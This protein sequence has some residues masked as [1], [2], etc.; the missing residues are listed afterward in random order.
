MVGLAHPW[1]PASTRPKTMADTP[2]VEVSAPA[3]SKRPRWRSVSTMTSRPSSQTTTPMGTFT[4]ITHRQETSWVSSPPATSPV[5]PPA[6]DT[7][8]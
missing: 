5:A 3:R 4:N 7:V 1:L 6:A 8:V 2:R